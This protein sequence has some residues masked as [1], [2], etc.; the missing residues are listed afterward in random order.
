[1]FSRAPVLRTG[2]ADVRFRT[3]LGNMAGV[4]CAEA[5]SVELEE[6]CQEIDVR[7]RRTLAFGAEIGS[8]TL[9]DQDEYVCV[10]Y[11]VPSMFSGKERLSPIR[12]ALLLTLA[13]RFFYS[14]LGVLFA[15]LLSLDAERIR[16]N[17]TD[18]G[19]IERSEGLRFLLLG[20]WQRFDAIWYLHI[21]RSGYDL[22]AAAVFYPLYPALIKFL[23]IFVREPLAA[24]L[25]V[26]T[27]AAFLF[28]WGLENLLAV[29]LEPDFVRR[30]VLLAAAWPA[31]FTLFAGYA[32]SLLAAL[33]VWAVYSARRERWAAA[34][35]LAFAAGLAKAAGALVC[36]P[37]LVLAWKKPWRAKLAAAAG[38]A[39]PA[40]F[41]VWLESTG[42]QS[43]GAVYP[44]Y[45]HT[46]NAWPMDTLLES[47]AGAFAL[48]PVILLNL[49]VLLL[50]TFL[51]LKKRF[52]LEYTLFGISAVLV[53][54]SKRTE[55]LLQS[56]LRY[57]VI[58]FPAYP[59]A[60]A[61]LKS[62]TWL[63][64]VLAGALLLN[65]AM[66]YLFFDWWILV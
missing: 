19:L 36:V 11:N 56:T 54:L 62:R 55:P 29:D 37:L 2:Q 47:L 30:S 25:L 65:V 8:P 38:L 39:G 34:G 52:R 41:T 22:P 57:L 4:V 33:L 23:S 26:S 10:R 16:G 20:V 35:T 46:V 1:M 59:A 18:T 53:F 48:H 13:L 14:L 7:R 27:V 66:L 32:E 17:F 28:F 45:W 42:R 6:L 51:V 64:V 21:A 9:P 63:V 50:V 12:F 60:A 24:A 44:K 49:P 15:P 3:Q 5:A 58:V 43:A 40:V 31:S 61:Y